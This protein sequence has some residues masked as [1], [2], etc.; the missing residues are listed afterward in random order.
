MAGSLPDES[1]RSPFS[2]PIIAARIE[3]IRQLA[4]GMSDRVAVMDS[5]FNVVYANASAWTDRAPDEAP[6]QSAKCYQAFADRADPCEACPATKVFESPEVQAVSCAAKGDGA[7]CGIDRK[8]TRLN[9]SHIPLSR[10]P[11][12]A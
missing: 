6:A 8:S 5:E 1:A 3:A 9:S 2:D 11:S 10:M 7:A 4:G 12:S